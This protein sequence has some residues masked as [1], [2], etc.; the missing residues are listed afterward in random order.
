MAHSDRSHAFYSYT[1][2]ALIRALINIS[3]ILDKAESHTA[4]NKIEPVNFLQARLYPDM[5]AL[6]QQLQYCCYLPVD[7]AQHFADEPAPRVGYDES[8]FK[9]VQASIQTTIGYLKSILPERLAERAARKVPAFFDPTK[10]MSAEDYGMSVI[11]PDFYFHATVAY[12]ILRH[13]GVPL[14]KNDF[15]GA[16]TLEPM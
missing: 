15:L 3:D 8:D 1:I 11:M 10:G 6:I 5:F 2:T 4:A 9:S 16:L 7:F 13:N 14:G 12:A